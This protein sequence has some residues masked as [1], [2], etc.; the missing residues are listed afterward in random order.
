MRARQRRHKTHESSETS[1]I[2]KF[3]K[4]QWAVAV[5]H[6]F[7]SKEQE[8]FNFMAAVTI[9]SDFRA[10]ENKICHCFHFSPSICHEVMGPAAMILVFFNTRTE[11]DGR[12]LRSPQAS[13]AQD[14][15]PRGEG[16]AAAFLAPPL[17]AQLAHVP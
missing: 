16:G 15:L 13:H 8:P 1:H 3:Q 7:P 11:T 12:A 9:H 6:S 4:E 2:D 5:S 10:Q 17:P 14:T